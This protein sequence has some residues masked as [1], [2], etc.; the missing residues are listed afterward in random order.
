MANRMSADLKRA[1]LAE[2][3]CLDE[4]ANEYER[5]LGGQSETVAIRATAVLVFRGQ[6]A[7]K[8]AAAAV[9]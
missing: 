7:A 9:L 4:V 3:K 8:R 5:L 6:A 1:L 2:A